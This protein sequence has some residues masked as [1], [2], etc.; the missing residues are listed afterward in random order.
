M[1]P[2]IAR[3]HALFSQALDKALPFEKAGTEDI[4]SKVST[5]SWSPTSSSSGWLMRLLL[6][7]DSR[8]NGP[9]ERNSQRAAHV[10]IHDVG[11]PVVRGETH[12][13]EIVIRLK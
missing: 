1:F 7:V 10:H 12:D 5:K 3:C 4:R 9:G 6:T 8:V 11:N 13:E 2:R